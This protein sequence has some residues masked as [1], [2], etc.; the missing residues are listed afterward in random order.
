[1]AWTS[2]PTPSDPVDA[3]AVRARWLRRLAWV[4]GAL[5]LGATFAAYLDPDLA[6]ELSSRVWAACFQ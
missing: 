3:A 4:G 6:V 2:I 1:M 5:V